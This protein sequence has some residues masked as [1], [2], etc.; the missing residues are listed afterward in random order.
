VAFVVGIFS[1]MFAGWAAARHKQA[2]LVL[3]ALDMALWHRDHGGHPV[4][5][6]PVH[7]SDAESQY[8]RP[9]LAAALATP[10]LECSGTVLPS[11][12]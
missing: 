2:K 5:A 9:G 4:S 7:H 12:W 6:G 10:G 8:C 11:A 3:D 1:R